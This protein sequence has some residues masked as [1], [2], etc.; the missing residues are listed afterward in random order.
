MSG[1]LFVTNGISTPLP[2]DAISRHSPA[3]RNQMAV[4][5]YKLA[6]VIHAIRQYLSPTAER[7]RLAE[8]SRELVEQQ[9]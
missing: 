1:E 3:I 9:E 6:V 5:G 2:A 7:P 4:V 8:C